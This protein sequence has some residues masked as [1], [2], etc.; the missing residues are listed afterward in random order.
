MV[1]LIFV[2]RR[3]SAAALLTFLYPLRLYLL[4]WQIEKSLSKLLLRVMFSYADNKQK[5]FFM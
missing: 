4:F 1:Q 3:Q 2:S 5:V